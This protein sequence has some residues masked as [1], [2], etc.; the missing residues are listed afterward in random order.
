MDGLSSEWRFS[1]TIAG[2]GKYYLFDHVGLRGQAQLLMTFINSSGGMFCSLP[3]G[4]FAGVT[5]Q[6]FIQGNLTL[7][8]V[9]GF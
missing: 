7:G 8:L 6:A 9:V 4:C 1:G 3:G 5:G 2:G